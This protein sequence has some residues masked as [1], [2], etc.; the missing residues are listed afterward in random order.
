MLKRVGNVVYELDLPHNLSSIHPVFYVS[1][2]RKCVGDAS[3]LVSI[4]MFVFRIPIV[5][6]KL[7]LRFWIGKSAIWGLRM[8]L[9]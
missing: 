8:W 1:M 3:L 4:E 9:R 6:M 5:I 2:L 7:L